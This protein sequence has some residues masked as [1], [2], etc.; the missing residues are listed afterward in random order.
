[1]TRFLEKGSGQICPTAL[2]RTSTQIFSKGVW[3][4]FEMIFDLQRLAALPDPS[5]ISP[6][7]YPIFHKLYQCKF[8]RHILEKVSCPSTSPGSRLSITK[9]SREIR[10]IVREERHHNFLSTRSC[11][12]S[13]VSDGRYLMV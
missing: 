1:M 3:Y 7:F 6:V 2:C 4:F 13:S 10:P 5:S 9:D 12:G 11:F 8:T